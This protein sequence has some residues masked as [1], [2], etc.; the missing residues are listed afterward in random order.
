MS[1]VTDRVDSLRG[2]ITLLEDEIM[3]FESENECLHE[4]ENG[5]FGLGPYDY[6]D[7]VMRVLSECLSSWTSE[8]WARL[9]RLCGE[10]AK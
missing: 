4:K 6:P 7:D 9:G 8:R 3:D 1:T 2:E 10:R 5:A